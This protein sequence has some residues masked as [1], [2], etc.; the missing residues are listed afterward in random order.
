[1]YR[2]P[3]PR[4]QLIPIK[5]ITKAIPMAVEKCNTKEI[6]NVLPKQQGASRGNGHVER[7]HK[8]MIG[9]NGHDPSN[10]SKM[11]PA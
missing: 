2:K 3:L 5:W 6:M 9:T 8:I 4:D 11:C 10:S 1:M 7:L